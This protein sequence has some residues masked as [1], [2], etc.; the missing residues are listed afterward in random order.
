[1]KH[2]Y[3]KN[4][5]A[6][7][8]TLLN[9]SG[10]VVAPPDW[11]WHIEF[12]DG[13]RKY[14]C[15]VDKG[16]AKV[17]G[18]TIMCYLDNHKFCCGEIGYKFVQAIPDL[19]YLD[20]FQNLITPKALP[21]ELWEQESDN[22]VNIQS[23]VVPAY[24]VYDAYMTAKANGYTGTAEEFYDA[25]NH[26]VDI[27][28]KEAERVEA[29]ANRVNAE[30]QRVENFVA[31]ESALTT[32]TSKANTATN[33]AEEA[34][35]MADNSATAATQA[36]T[37][38]TTATKRANDISA[39]L[40]AKREADYWRGAK[41]EKG[42]KGDT[43]AKGDRGEK[44]DKGER[45]LQGVQGVK[46]D[47]GVSPTV[48]TSKT[49][50]VTT[51]EITDAN[52][53]HTATVN[54]GE[55][56]NVVQSTGTSETAVMSQKA[57]TMA[58]AANTPSGD[59]LHNMYLTIGAVWNGDTGFWEMNGLN[60]LTNEDMLWIYKMSHVQPLPVDRVEFA[61][62]SYS[63]RLTNKARTTSTK[64]YGAGIGLVMPTFTWN[65]CI[66][67]IH[68]NYRNDPYLLFG[69]SVSLA[70]CNNLK[71]IRDTVIIDDIYADMA[72]DN[73]LVEVRFILKSNIKFGDSNKLSVA[74]VKYMIENASGATITI[75]L[76]PE[77]YE[78]AI[79][80][81]GVQTALANKT[82]VSLAKAE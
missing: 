49:G 28:K 37:Q 35:K 47:D 32:A 2:I 61:P 78:R 54:D 59:P 53:V 23:S 56:V 45:G 52:G 22:D 74:S 15:S 76:H 1:M 79:A 64:Y 46:G 19:N 68:F 34:S 65:C 4:D 67:I 27:N 44:G 10:E 63:Y 11:Q 16:N 26:I 30:Q 9:A 3:Y 60:D 66:E 41:G 81:A 29:E 17:V 51:I 6:V 57:S 8:I 72:Q 12:T 71:E 75:T 31:M 55:S 25:L 33:K 77:A 62:F 5:F 40:E 14:I 20:G 39:D 18:N 69:N 70:Y 21:I 7:E 43:G 24:V 36:T 48:S 38:A 82:N 80:D 73:E 50:K 13:R 42:D 58:F